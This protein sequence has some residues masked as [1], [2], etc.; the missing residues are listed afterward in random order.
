MREISERELDLPKVLAGELSKTLQKNKDIISLSF[1]EPDFNTQREV[2]NYGKKF[3]DKSH[4]YSYGKGLLKLRERIVNK[5]KKD[6]KINTN[7]ENII[8]TPGSQTAI[9]CSLM[10]IIDP[11]EKVIIPSPCYL[12]Y[13]PSIELVNGDVKYSK[14]DEDF[15]LDIDN[16][17]KL[18]S[19]KTRAIIINTPN[20]PTG[21]MYSKKLLEELAD[22]IVEKDLY[23]ISDEAY[24]KITYGKKHVSMGSLNGM[25]KYCL[26]I[27]SFSKT[28]SMCGFRLGYVNAPKKLVEPITKIFRYVSIAAPTISQIMGY[29]AMKVGNNYT[30]MMCKEYNKRRRFIVKRLNELNLS[31]RMPE[32][33]FYTFSDISAYSKDS[34]KFT[35][36]LIKKA[37]VAVVP[38]T[39]FGKFGE[40]YIR[41]SYATSM[42]LIKKAMN[43]I[44][45]VLL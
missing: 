1:G 6:N 36:Y 21:K 9:L 10:S 42:D 30:K 18:S 29:E 22:L 13:V 2:I 44:E 31:T 23:V 32:G 26:T 8:L 43:R 4:R 15:N 37:R 5:L 27:Q 17:K 28:Y 20:N 12:G 38:G 19:K 35:R 7:K 41:L 11:G 40:N 3:L 34:I 14:L 25:N 39:E 45:K 33:A 24:E 16:I